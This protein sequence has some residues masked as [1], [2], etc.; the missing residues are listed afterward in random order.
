MKK[1]AL[2]LFVTSTCFLMTNS[3]AGGCGGCQ[4]QS[5]KTTESKDGAICVKEVVS[6]EAEPAEKQPETEV[7]AVSN[8]DAE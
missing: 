2:F 3:Y 6:E 1:I 8:T 7:Q 5:E 4:A